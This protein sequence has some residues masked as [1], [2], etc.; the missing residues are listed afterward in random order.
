MPT[1]VGEIIVDG[2]LRTL[3]VSPRDDTDRHQ[4]P[5]ASEGE[6]AETFKQSL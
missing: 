3:H 2:R 6:D 1:L 4:V 5:N